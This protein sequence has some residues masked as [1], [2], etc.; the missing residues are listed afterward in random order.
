MS[1]SA[2]GQFDKQGNY[3][4]WL[5]NQA[6][7]NRERVEMLMLKKY[8]KSHWNILTFVERSQMIKVF[9]NYM[10]K[11]NETKAKKVRQQIMAIWS[12]H[13]YSKDDLHG[14]MVAWGFGDSLRA[15]K[16]SRLLEVQKF[17][18]IAIKGTE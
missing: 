8:K 7:W 4:W 15:L 11:G 12:T 10:E 16:L 3:F 6:G 2:E 9:K 13:G 17:V 14:Y 5:V 1:Y 18:R